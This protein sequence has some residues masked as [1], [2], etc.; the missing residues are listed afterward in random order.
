M[1]SPSTIVQQLAMRRQRRP[2]KA[3]L[4]AEQRAWLLAGIHE[5]HAAG[6]LVDNLRGDG[7]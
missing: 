4:G 5:A 3:A 1:G 2:S 6:L 7:V